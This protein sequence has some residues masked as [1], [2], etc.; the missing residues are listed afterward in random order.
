MRLSYRAE[1]LERL[2]PYEIVTHLAD[3]GMSQIFLAFRRGEGG[4]Q[5]L[6]VLKRILPDASRDEGFV[7]RLLEEGRMLAGFSHPNIV[8]VFDLCREG[9]EYFLVMEFISG[10]TLLEL[11]KASVEAGERLPVDFTLSVGRSVALALHHAHTIVDPSGIPTPVIHRDVAPKNIM[12][13]FGG[14]AKVIDFGIAKSQAHKTGGG[15]LIGTPAYMAPEQIALKRVDA[16]S[17]V[18]G[19][20]VT[21]HECLTGRR[22]FSADTAE[23]QIEAVISRPIEP[24]SALNPAV[25]SAVDQAILRAVAR[26]PEQRFSS[27]RELGRALEAATDGPPWGPERIAAVVARFFPDR[28]EGLRR[29]LRRVEEGAVDRR[30]GL[31][32]PNEV[33]PFDAGR[34]RRRLRAALA[35]TVAGAALVTLSV[36]SGVWRSPSA[37]ALASAAMPTVGLEGSSGVAPAASPTPPPSGASDRPAPAVAPRV[38]EGTDV[39]A[40]PS[41]KAPGRGA[42]QARARGEATAT[43]SVK[44]RPWAR[45]FVDG[46]LQGETPLDPFRVSAGHHTV[47]LVN[48]EL[49]AKKSIDLELRANEL[50][51]L[52]VLFDEH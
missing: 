29:F 11:L 36:V 22:L 20:G 39:P 47:L 30:H 1:M 45:I 51:E 15:V 21:L 5:K 34:G 32:T 16:R 37:P 6:V 38:P 3:G 13:T 27:A 28:E 24:P 42:K 35:V 23:E 50:R 9:D 25:T 43:L 52:K 33:V 48:D 44:V 12:I 7:G 49:N 18:F 40:R 17:D 31:A 8:Q 10:V 41:R 19:L 26:P 14:D 46:R 2:G 4:F